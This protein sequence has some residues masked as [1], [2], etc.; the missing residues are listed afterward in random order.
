MITYCKLMVN[1]F[2]IIIV[3]KFEFFCFK[4]QRFHLFGY[5]VGVRNL[6][7]WGENKTKIVNI[8]NFAGAGL[9]HGARTVPNHMGQ[10]KHE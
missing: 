9:P 5:R 4:S 1:Y 7:P 2:S 10:R 3:W 6:A 8:V